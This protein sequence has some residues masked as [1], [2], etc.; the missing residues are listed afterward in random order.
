MDEAS[1]GLGQAS[2]CDSVTARG[3]TGNSFC[4]CVNEGTGFDDKRNL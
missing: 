4:L 3:D 2:F 1:G